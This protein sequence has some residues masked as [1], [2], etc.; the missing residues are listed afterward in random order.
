M[1]IYLVFKA[2]NQI[3]LSQSLASVVPKT[4]MN[5]DIISQLELQVADRVRNSLADIIK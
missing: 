3:D 2:K 5:Y 1:R 4:I